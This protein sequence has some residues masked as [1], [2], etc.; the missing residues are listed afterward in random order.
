MASGFHTIAPTPASTRCSQGIRR[1]RKVWRRG[2]PADTTLS[3]LV[4]NAGYLVKTAAGAPNFALQLTGHPLPPEQ[5]FKSSGLNFAGFPTPIPDSS[6]LRNIETFF[7]YST[8]LKESGLD[9]HA[10][11]H[12]T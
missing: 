8:V 10:A 9:Y 5:A 2:L 11:H 7:S 3:Y 12:T 1:F 4:G 6:A